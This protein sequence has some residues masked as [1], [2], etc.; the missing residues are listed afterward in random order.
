MFAGVLHKNSGRMFFG[1]NT[2]PGALPNNL[3][4]EM[5][6]R[7]VEAEST[8]GYARTH[9]AGTH[10]EVHA[11]NEGLVAH[12]GSEVSDFLIYAINSGQKGSAARWGQPVPRCPHCEFI[13]DGADFYPPLRYGK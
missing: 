1:K 3:T 9:G 13:T 10:A 11:L 12:P 8:I 5:A 4:P 6:N 7:I 2:T